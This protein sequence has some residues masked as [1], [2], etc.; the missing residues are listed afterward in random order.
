M[1]KIIFDSYMGP[2]LLPIQYGTTRDNYLKYLRLPD[3]QKY[4]R[5]DRNF[6]CLFCFP[7]HTKHEHSSKGE[8]FFHS[9]RDEK[10]KQILPV[11]LFTTLILH[12]INFTPRC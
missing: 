8:I 11:S 1:V 10:V 2:C 5:T 9:V 4:R 12:T 6:F 3:R 7:R